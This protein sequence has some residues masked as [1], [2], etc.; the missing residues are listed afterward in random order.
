MKPKL[1]IF[2]NKISCESKV[3]LKKYDVKYQLVLPDQH[4]HNAVERSIYTFKNHFISRLATSPPNFSMKE[5]DIL[6]KVA[7]IILSIRCNSRSN[8]KLSANVFLHGVFDC[9]KDPLAS[10]STQVD[11]HEKDIHHRSWDY[12]GKDAWYVGPE[13]KH[14]QCVSA[15][16]PHTGQE[17]IWNKVKFSQKKAHFWKPL[18][19]II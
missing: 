17:L 14:H 6:L 5:W 10:H 1:F 3:A 9:N 12:H 4:R 13:M 18:R 19:V 15:Y 2:D 7:I 8:P 16:I 11:A